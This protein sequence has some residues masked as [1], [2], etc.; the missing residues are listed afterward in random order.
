MIYLGLIGTNGAGKS[1]VCRYLRTHGFMVISLSDYVREEVTRRGLSLDRDNM[2]EVANTLKREYGKD[3]L[4]KQVLDVAESLKTEKV[5]F[6]SVRN[7]QEII[8]LKNKGAI[9]LGVDAP[10]ELRFERVKSRQRE[11]DFVNFDTFVAQDERENSGVS[12]GQNIR[13]CLKL[14]DKV[15]INAHD[16]NNLFSEVE[17]FLKMAIELKESK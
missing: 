4:A 10:L 5:V 3:Y 8:H 9:L 14:C 11:T 7:M 6:D 12:Y 13:E 16:E 2:V 1:T 15:V 17:A